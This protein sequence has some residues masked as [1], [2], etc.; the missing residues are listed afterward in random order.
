MARFSTQVKL[1]VLERRAQGVGWKAIKE[2]IEEEFHIDPPTTRAMQKWEKNL[3]RTALNR[4][5][6][7]AMGREAPAIAEDAQ[8]RLAQGLLPVLWQ[9]KDAGGDMELAGWKWFFSLVESQLGSNKFEYFLSEYMK[10]RE[11]LGGKRQ[12]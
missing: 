3:D 1:F 10:D 11:K 6:M 7:K 8:Q 5:I 2:G 9:A 12:S 4:Q